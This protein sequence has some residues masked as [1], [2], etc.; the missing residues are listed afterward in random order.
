VPIEVPPSEAIHFTF[1]RAGRAADVLELKH[2]RKAYGPLRF[3]ISR[4][5]SSAAI[6]SRSSVQRRQSTLMRMLSAEE[7]PTA[8][9]DRGARDRHRYSRGRG[10]RQSDLTVYERS[11][12]DRP[13]TWCRR[14]R[15]ILGGFLFSGDDVYRRGRA[16]GGERTPSGRAHADA[17]LDTLAA[18]RADQPP[19]SHSKDVLLEALEITAAR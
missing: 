13:P 8:A 3:R 1:R 18:R 11:R 7:T 4:C 17:A 2:V 15:N 5:T 19:R 10:Q 16:V 9:R 14:F 6:A 12:P